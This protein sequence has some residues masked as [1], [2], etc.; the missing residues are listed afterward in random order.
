MKSF[1]IN[2]ARAIERK[3]AFLQA[4]QSHQWEVEVF[5]AVDWRE[6]EVETLDNGGRS[7]SVPGTDLML[8]VSGPRAGADPLSLGEIACALSHISLWRKILAENLPAA[9]IFED[10]AAL[11]APWKGA[12]WP[13]DADLVFINDRVSA[14][15]PEDLEESE[16]E[17]W[18]QRTAYAAMIPGCGMEGY[19]IT[20]QGAAKALALMETLHVPLD[21]QIMAAGQ[22]TLETDHSL[23]A[24]RRPGHE[25]QLYATT[26]AFTSHDDQS[27]SYIS[28]SPGRRRIQFGSGG[29][30][31]EGW[32][33]CDLPDHDI[34]LPL[35][36]PAASLEAIFAE[37][38]IEHITPREAW[39]FLSE[40]HRV[41]RPGGVVRLAFPDVRR[42]LN[43]PQLYHDFARNCGWGDGTA[44]GSVR[45]VLFEHGHLGAWTAQSLGAVMESLG[46][47]VTEHRPLQSED[48][49]MRGLE[50]HW[51]TVGLEV[52]DAETSVL[53]G[54][55][56]DL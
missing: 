27:F 5:P 36:F 54:R 35:K 56:A 29:I 25:L 9:F 34:R 30:E 31:I 28:E 14:L 18:C 19:L 33:N 10:D 50:Q 52:N 24:H 2:L 41:L 21:L 43:A 55:R 15:V 6:L 13:T 44:Q 45:G 46:F 4:A 37:H 12:A 47:Q 3:A 42:I 1:V 40:C 16:L 38:V 48:E 32:R 22:G 53:E 39:S 51:K 17:A 26:E 20:Q 7:V 8:T 11:I 49:M 23:L